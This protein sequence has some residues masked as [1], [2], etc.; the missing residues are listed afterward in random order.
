MRILQQI[1]AVTAMNVRNL[2][3]R[4]GSSL[5]VVIGIGGVVGV[6]VSVL[7]M[8]NGLTGTLLSA[9]QPDRAIVMRSGATNEGGSS[10]GLDGVQTIMDAPGVARLASGEPAVSAEIFGSINLLRKSD[11]NRSG[12]VVRGLSPQGLEIRDEVKLTE[13]RWFRPGLREVVVGRGARQE[14]QGLELG[15]K[16]PIRDGEWTIVGVL[17]SG[18]TSVE[19]TLVTDA[20][21]LLSAYQRTVYN[22]VRVRLESADAFTTFRDALTTN[23]AL[24]VTVLTEEEYQRQTA[25]GVS[26]LFSVITYVVGGIMAL[27]ALFAALNTMYSAVSGR[28]VEIATLRAIGFGASGV[29]ISVLVEA[30]LLALLG[31]LAGAGVAALLF[32]GNT[33]S[34]GG[35]TGTLVTEMR[36]TLPVLASGVAWACT[37]GLLGGLLPA[38][39]AARLP[40]ATALRAL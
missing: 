21:T 30:L 24:S 34:L 16:I 4:V 33:I 40:V 20:D 35:N 22:S 6:L 15:N 26:T 36:V 28:A 3:Q 8:S 27:G 29:V 1:A 31:A 25:R 23:P 19:A 2:P 14:F 9:A 12:V 37:V 10:V 32:N 39:R 17:E 38:V 5:V 18:G 7:A 13:G 11:G